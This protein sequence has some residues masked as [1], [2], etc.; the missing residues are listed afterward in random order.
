MQS[1]T[2][3]SYTSVVILALRFVT[4]TPNCFAR[5]TIAILFLDETACEILVS[6]NCCL[7]YVTQETNSAA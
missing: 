4:L 1:L 3:T 5:A 6:V 7:H 2:K